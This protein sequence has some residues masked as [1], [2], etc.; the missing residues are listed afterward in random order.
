MANLATRRIFSSFLKHEIRSQCS[1]SSNS[2]TPQICIV[3]GGPAGFYTASQILKHHKQAHVDIYEKL[4]APYGLVRYGVAPDHPEVKNVIHAFETTAN[5]NRCAFLGN[6][7]VGKDISMQELQKNYH[8]VVLAYGAETDKIIDIPGEDA[9][10]VLS[11]RAFVGWYNGLPENFDLNPDLSSETAVIVGMGNV[12]LDVARILLS[13]ISL[14]EKTDISEHALEILRNSKVKNVYIV[15]RRGPLQ[16]AFTIKELREM[17][18]MP[19]CETVIDEEYVKNLPNKYEANPLNNRKTH[20]LS[21]MAIMS[22][23]S[24]EHCFN[25]IPFLLQEDSSENPR[26]IQTGKFEN[27]ECGLVIRSIGS[28]SS[29]I[30]ATLPFDENK[31]IIPSKDHRVGGYPGLYCSGWVGSGPVGVILNT[32]SNS[33]RTG[34]I[35][36]EDLD[37]GILG[38]DQRGGKEEIA[39]VIGRKGVRPVLFE[40]WIRVDQ[41]EVKRGEK[42]GKPREK[43]I[44]TREMLN[45]AWHKHS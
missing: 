9:Q 12:A 42:S 33:F 8:A 25:S 5:N 30:D 40:E 10:N 45:F 41:E 31:G 23:D 13:P 21:Q 18:D 6:V 38:S 2:F 28:V 34:D 24:C 22:T 36:I 37:K 39:R 4:P 16:V 3:G 1:F 32:M 14:L 43:M 19:D 29:N 11:A 44:K 17:I 20:K 35:V 26:Y 7:N 15:G 27:I